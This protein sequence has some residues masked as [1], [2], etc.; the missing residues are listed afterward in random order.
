M[1]TYTNTLQEVFETSDNWIT[2]F[3]NLLSDGVSVNEVLASS[4]YYVLMENLRVSDGIT[5]SGTF[6]SSLVD[7]VA[8]ED[9]IRVLFPIV[10]SDSLDLDDNPVELLLRLS[11]IIETMRVNDT[12]SS[13]ATFNVALAISMTIADLVSQAYRI[14][15]IEEI[16]LADTLVDLFVRS[17]ILIDQIEATLVNQN[18]LIL[19]VHVEDSIQLD[20]S[21]S[22]SGILRSI[23]VD[24]FQ[25]VGALQTDEL[26]NTYS[27]NPEG[28]AIST[29]SNY[30]FNSIAEYD[31]K[32]IL[33]NTTGLYEFGGTTDNLSEIIAKLKTSAIDFG[34]SSKKQ[35]KKMYLGIT[36]DSSIVLKVTTDGEGTFYYELDSST[37]GLD[38]QAIKIGK[39]LVGRYWQ[40]E[41]I[42]KDNSSLELDEMEFLPVEFRRKL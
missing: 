23:L 12:P 28:F 42:T 19:G 25:F 14:N 22:L 17:A 24:Q 3:F 13:V 27:F 35:V 21:L 37:V 11:E 5:L 29:Y 10:L 4:V 39:G 33:A 16:D 18:F 2:A 32:Y 38:T 40:F 7:Q 9:Q 1:A 34:T 31:G 6:N 30:H 8:L 36:N 41:L 26:Y 20:D 15:I